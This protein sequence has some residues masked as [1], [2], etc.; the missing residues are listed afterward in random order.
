MDTELPIFDTLPYIL[1]YAWISS[2]GDAGKG[3]IAPM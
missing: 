2:D 3:T 1:L